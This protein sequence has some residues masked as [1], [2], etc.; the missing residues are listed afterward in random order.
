V[1]H[2]C[3]FARKTFSFFMSA[4]VAVLCVQLD[5]RAEA[6][7]LGTVS[8]SSGNGAATNPTLRAERGTAAAIAPTQANLS[9]TEPQSV[10]SRA[11]IENSTPPTGNFNTILSIAPSI[12]SMPATNGPGLSDQKMTLRGFQDGE[13]N[14]T[15]DGIPFGDT[16]GP[17][18]H[19][20]AY[21]P[22]SVI[23]G[24]VIERGPGNASNI[25]YSTY[26][27]SVNIVSKAPSEEQFTR[28]Y[29]TFGRWNTALEGVAFE[30]GRLSNDATVQLNLQHMS[31]DGYLSEAGQVNK[32]LTI[33]FQKP[34]GSS[35]VLTAFMSVADVKTYTPDNS[36]GPNA[37]QVAALGKNFSLNND[38]TSQAYKNF[39]FQ[40]KQTN[41][42]Y[43]RLQGAVGD[44][45]EI[46][47]NAYTYSYI[48]NTIAGQDPSQYMPGGDLSK[49]FTD[50][51]KKKHT[52]ANGDV[53]GYYK[54]NEYIVFGDV[55]RS[56]RKFDA[57][58]L[59][60]G[61]WYE[62]ST[63]ERHNLEADLTQGVQLAGASTAYPTGVVTSSNF[64]RQDSHWN[65]VQPFVEFEW[66]VA[67]GL[68]ITPGYKTMS[69]RMGLRSA[70]NQKALVPQDYG[71]TYHANLPFLTVNQRLGEQ[72]SLYAQ[73]ARGLQ[74]PFLGVGSATATP[75][76]PQQT[77][78][79]QA[80]WVHKSESLTLGG[81][82]YFISMNNMQLNTGTPANPNYVNVGGVTYKGIEAEA[83]YVLGHGFAVYAN[84]SVNSANYLASNAA[85][86]Q[87]TGQVPNAPNMTSAAGVLYSLNSWDASL[88]FKR[89]GQQLNTKLGGQLPS[90]DNVDLNVAYTFEHLG[91]S[92]VKSARL[93]FSTFNLTNQQRLVA[94]TGPLTSASSQLQWQA[95]RSYM[96]SG[97]V[98]F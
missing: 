20:T 90:I 54:L 36:S 87:P 80:G 71:Y 75:P 18:H 72:D 8:G 57:G 66:A 70:L 23:G 37:A 88:L 60:M 63:T 65:Q 7:D 74:V 94:T 79:Y 85:A 9:A 61:F 53:P 83:T 47:N 98:D 96:L 40:S 33:K 32:N 1:T 29:G 59:R 27:G 48:N 24:L 41:M 69:Y 93:Q 22:A 30:S 31:S 49:T 17:T 73:Y 77:T 5:A 84:Y 38:P 50:L 97:R 2:S 64:D 81:D 91:V 34:L 10:I 51:L 16:N 39:N 95:P 62:G 13:Y 26:G 78:N 3:P 56:T 12:S 76:A 46:D 21:F 92:W 6:V 28:V 82:V 19:S 43:L 89:I 68:T 44:G 52:L 35:F 25:G 42:E 15:F 58:L 55:F 45:W 11:F 86:G 67:P 4:A 14:V